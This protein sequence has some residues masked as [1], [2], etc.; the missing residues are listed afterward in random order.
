MESG[1]EPSALGDT[2]LSF[3]WWRGKE[4][5]FEISPPFC[6]MSSEFEGDFKAQWLET[7]WNLSYPDAS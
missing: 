5:G 2:E 7:K 6:H 1:K 3:G 4:G